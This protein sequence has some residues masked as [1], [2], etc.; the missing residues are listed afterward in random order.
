M[1]D[2]PVSGFIAR[3]LAD[4]D[5]IVQQAMVDY[6]A[7]AASCAIT[8]GRRLVA[9]RGYGYLDNEFEVPTPSGV[10]MRLASVDKLILVTAA[11]LFCSSGYAMPETGVPISQDLRVFEAMRGSWA[12]EPPPGMEADPRIYDVTIRHLLE[13]RSGIGEVSNACSEVMA[14]LGSPSAPTPWEIPRYLMGAPLKAAPGAMECY[15]NAALGMVKYFID[16][17]F[18]DDGGYLGYVQTSVFAPI[19]EGLELPASLM[20]D[21]VISR[22]SPR[23]RDSREPVYI[24]EETG[25]STFPGDEGRTVSA[26]DGGANNID[27]WMALGTSAEA[28]AGT[29]TTGTWGMQGRS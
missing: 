17:Y 10:I 22:A 19:A 8:F 1:Q 11:E 27:A 4:V 14:A 12:L 16:R 7:S 6:R 23:E 20:D 15:A 9:C 28:C 29:A 25:P 18:R 24:S 2:I 13:G 5:A 21:V 26:A 3:E